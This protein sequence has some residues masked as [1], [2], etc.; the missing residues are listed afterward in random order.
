MANG[1]VHHG[2][3]F[4]VKLSVAVRD[5]LHRMPMPSIHHGRSADYTSLTAFAAEDSRAITLHI[6]S[7]GY[8][9]GFLAQDKC[10]L[11][12]RQAFSCELDV[13]VQNLE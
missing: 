6:R 12:L 13:Q 10:D 5:R 4:C 8:R 11:M 9:V 1:H 3:F 2:Q 7:V